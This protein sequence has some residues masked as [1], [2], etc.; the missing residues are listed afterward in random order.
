[1]LYRYDKILHSSSSCQ[2]TGVGRNPS[3]PRTAQ[4]KITTNLKSIN[5]QKHQ[6]IKLHG[7]ATTQELKTQ[8]TRP[9]RPVRWVDRENPQQGGGPRSLGWLD[10]KLR[11]RA[12][13]RLPRGFPQW[14]KLPVSQESYLE[15]GVESNRWAALFP[16]WLLLHRQCCPGEYLRPRPPLTT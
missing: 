6:K 14:E 5:K 13:C 16:L 10:G 11:H 9:P 1:M 3:L 15:S 4:R 12:A 2:D 8:S 7:T